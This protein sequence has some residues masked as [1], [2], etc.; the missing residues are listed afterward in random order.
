[1]TLAT[2]EART[3]SSRLPAKVLADLHGR[4]MLER[5]IERVSRATV[6]D[7]I[8]I[9]TTTAPEDDVLE[10][11]AR[12]LGVGCHRGSVEDVLGRVLG[13]AQACGTDDL[14][15]LTGDNPLVDPELIDDVVAFYR[16]GRFDYVTTTHMHHSRQWRAERTFPVGVSVQ[17]FSTKALV[18]A[19]ASTTDPVD[20]EHVSFYIYNHPERY[21]LGAFVA[22]GKYATWKK[23]ELRLTVDMPEDLALMRAIFQ[24]LYPGN[25]GFSTGEAIRLVESSQGLKAMNAHIRQRIVSEQRSAQA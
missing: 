19:S 4:P 17:V 22:E 15:A 14:V 24:A 1:M 10:G 6:L 3:G 8:V 11:L 16:H 5:L 2:I 9:A 21:R 7:G 25:P 12:K 20:R 13:A 18:E 23:P